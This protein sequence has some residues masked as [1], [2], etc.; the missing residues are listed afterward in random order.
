MEKGRQYDICVEFF[1]NIGTCEAHLGLAYYGEGNEIELAAKAAAESDVAIIYAGL[2]ET[3]EGEGNDRATLSLPE[4]QIKL[5]NSVAKANP[6]T[7]VVLFNGT[8]ITMNEWIDNVPGLIDA[9]YPGQEGGNALADILFGDVNPSGK[10]PLTFMKKWEDSAVYSTYPGDRDVSYYKEGIFVGYRH[11]DKA[12]IEPLFPFGYGLSYTKF[13]Y[14]DLKFD[15]SDMAQ[16]D[17]LMVSLL[18]RNAGKMD[19]DEVVQLYI[20]DKKSSVV[21]EVK[22]LKGFKRIFLK[23]GESRKVTMRIDKSH[24]SF[25]DVKNKKWLAEAGEFEVMIGSSSRDIRVTGTFELM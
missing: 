10:L 1:E 20:H 22:S 8:P 2:R 4:T 21:R 7:I 5:I 12:D 18:I 14:S 9:F 23:S 6:K 3:L 16:D 13:E 19:G 25:Y 17:T 15:K 11:F 24:L